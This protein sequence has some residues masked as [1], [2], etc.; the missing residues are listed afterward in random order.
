MRLLPGDRRQRRRRRRRQVPESGYTEERSIGF[1][2]RDATGALRVFPRDA[3]F[4]AP[5]LF[6]GQADLSG[7]EPSGLDIRRG[8]STRPAELDHETAVATLLE[9]RDPATEP[10]WAGPARPTRRRSYREA[11]LAPGDPVT[12]VGRALPFSDLADPDAADSG[13]GS[14][15][16]LDDPEVAADL[17]AARASGTLAGSAA[18]AWG[19]A[20]IAGFGIGR[21]VS[22]PAIDPDADPLPL[23]DAE[24]AANSARRFE[25]EPE[26]LV[27]AASAEVPLLIAFGIPGAVV[28]RGRDRFAVGL[29]GA[30]L[31][32]ASA[33]VLAISV[34]GGLAS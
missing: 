14:A 27:I 22:A 7:D 5:I 32:I 12:I 18:E 20:A 11:R 2:V 26:T 33:M 8:G 31:A 28:A 23:A 4:D 16:A 1:R 34:S 15:I 29:L 19:N 3:T 10:D 13:S 6:E 25:I 21:P 9:V 24:A 30:L 17:A